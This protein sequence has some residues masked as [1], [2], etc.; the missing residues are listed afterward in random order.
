MLL[1]LNGPFIGTI[2]FDPGAFVF[3]LTASGSGDFF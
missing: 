2:D 3:N 1:I